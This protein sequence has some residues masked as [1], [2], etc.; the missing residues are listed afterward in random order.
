MI[1][2]TYNV[3]KR[4]QPCCL[5]LTVLQKHSIHD[6]LWVWEREAHI[7][8]SMVTC[9]GSTR[10]WN[11]LEVYWPCAG[12][13]SAVNVIGTQLRDPINS[14]LT[15]W[16][17]AVLNKSMNAAAELERNPVV[18]K[19]Q[20][21]QPEHGDEQAD[22][23][24]DSRTRLARSYSQARTRDRK[25]SIFPVQLTTSRIDDQTL[26]TRLIHTLLLLLYV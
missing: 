1:T 20:K 8:W 7:N 12:G 6:M 25:I 22:A 3:G 26:I 2:Y 24:R 4:Y 14:G 16:R 19:H 10:Y 21:I 18:S 23:G 11:C 15:R 17:M 9:Q 5:R 13:L